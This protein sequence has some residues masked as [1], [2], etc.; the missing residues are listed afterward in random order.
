M[1]AGCGPAELPE[2]RIGNDGTEIGWEAVSGPD[3]SV[4]AACGCIAVVRIR[5]SE[6]SVLVWVR[7]GYPHNE[8]GLKADG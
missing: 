3:D 4:P 2:E 8:G 1:C 7:D 6:G 5:M